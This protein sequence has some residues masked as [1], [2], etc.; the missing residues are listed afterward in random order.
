MKFCHHNGN[1]VAFWIWRGDEDDY[2]ERHFE[3]PMCGASQLHCV[4]K[5]FIDLQEMSSDAKENIVSSILSSSSEPAMSSSL[6]RFQSPLSHFSFSILILNA[7]YF[8]RVSLQLFNCQYFWKNSISV[9]IVWRYWSF[10]YQR[11][12]RKEFIIGRPYLYICFGP[13]N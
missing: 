3:K 13:F 10:K 8:H 12:W 7:R 11:A 9:L 2:F 4:A 6:N 1:I 5:H